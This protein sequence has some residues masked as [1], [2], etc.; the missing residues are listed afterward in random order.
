M[1][2]LEVKPRVNCNEKVAFPSSETYR[3]MLYSMREIKDFIL[4]TKGDN[5]KRLGYTVY[6]THWS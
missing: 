5:T 1:K 2:R 4:V 6:E 3:Y